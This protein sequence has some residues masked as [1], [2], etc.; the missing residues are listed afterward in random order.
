MLKVPLPVLSQEVTSSN[1]PRPTIPSITI[2]LLDFLPHYLAK[3]MI[4]VG[5]NYSLP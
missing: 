5:N 1:S 3:G 2:G 4:V